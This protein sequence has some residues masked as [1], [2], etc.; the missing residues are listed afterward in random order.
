MTEE[1]GQATFI[2][3]LS[4]E[5]VDIAVLKKM[6]VPI[7]AVVDGRLKIHFLTN[8]TVPD[9][10]AN[11]ITEAIVEFLNDEGIPVWK[12]IGLRS[13]GAAVMMRDWSWWVFVLIADNTSSTELPAKIF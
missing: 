11:T 9:R 5:S 3:I 13:Y 4:D 1:I 7:C 12:V 8:M 2:G 6:A 10:T